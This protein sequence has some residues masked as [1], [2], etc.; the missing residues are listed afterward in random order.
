MESMATHSHFYTGMIAWSKT[1]FF[2]VPGTCSVGHHLYQQHSPQSSKQVQTPTWYIW[3]YLCSDLLHFWKAKCGFQRWLSF[4]NN[5]LI[6]KLSSS[7]K[8]QILLCT[9]QSFTTF[10]PFSTLFAEHPSHICPW[11]Q[12]PPQR[13][14]AS[15]RSQGGLS[16]PPGGAP[17]CLK[18]FAT[19]VRFKC[20]RTAEKRFFVIFQFH[21]FED[22]DLWSLCRG[23]GLP[24]V[25]TELGFETCP[26]FQEPLHFRRIATLRCLPQRTSTRTLQSC[27]LCL[28]GLLN[29]LAPICFESY[30]MQSL[31][32]TVTRP[33][34][35]WVF[36]YT[37]LKTKHQDSS[38][39]KDIR[40]SWRRIDLAV[41]VA[42]DPKVQSN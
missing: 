37:Q 18:W 6:L 42:W 14:R 5:L 26:A 32:W 27:S 24:A 16:S 11:N 12:R 1:P 22:L 13:L 30:L 36:S 41:T 8:Y 2:Q 3:I 17:C 21:I 31:M 19:A 9:P 34:N 7:K 39:S 29:K 15:P 33:L 35:S 40:T 10:H 38:V 4:Q 28:V 25:R 20:S 23:P